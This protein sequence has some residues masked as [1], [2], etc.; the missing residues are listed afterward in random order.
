M[1][2]FSKRKGEPKEE[3]AGRPPLLSQKVHKA[4]IDAVE[5][6]GMMEGRAA[7]AIGVSPSSVTIWKKRGQKALKEWDSLPPEKQAL[8]ARYCEFFKALRD[9]EPKFEMANLTIIQNAAS[10]GD[11]RAAKERLAMKMPDAYGK[12]M[13]I[14]GDPHNPLPVPITG[15]RV[16]IYMPDNG[17]NPGLLKP[18]APPA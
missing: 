18:D 11:W 5:L 13:M 4:I 14:G 6:L 7:S 3:G 17:R 15:A 16:Q 10:K 8:E 1:P 2:G 9:A 12:R